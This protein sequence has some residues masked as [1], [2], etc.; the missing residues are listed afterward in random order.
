MNTTA[1]STAVPTASS[2]SATSLLS[3]P[4]LYGTAPVVPKVSPCSLG[5]ASAVPV[6][7]EGQSSTSTIPVPIGPPSSTLDKELPRKA[8]GYRSPSAQASSAGGSSIFAEQAVS[9][10][11]SSVSSTPPPSVTSVGADPSRCTMG[12]P[13]APIAPPPGFTSLVSEVGKSVTA[14]SA[15]NSLSSHSVESPAVEIASSPLT[16][17]SLPLGKLPCADSL[18][19]TGTSNDLSSMQFLDESTRAKLA[20]VS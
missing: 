17:S 16:A 7:S 3:G 15:L 12:S 5:S 8:P 2:P 10:V 18:T 14:K 20:E 4:S 11:P 6:K 1:I 13:P 9:S 19:P